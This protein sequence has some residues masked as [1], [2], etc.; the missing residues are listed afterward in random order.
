[1]NNIESKELQ[2]YINS[3]ITAIKNGVAGTGF[4]IVKPIEFNLAVTNTAEGSGGLKIYVA[5]AEGKLK[6]EEIS[7][8][9]F[10]VKPEP[11][12][13]NQFRPNLNSNRN[14]AR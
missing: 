7:H 1:M 3:S 5:K 2:E 14:S 10:E 13:V 6:S 11:K 8:L 9:K 12:I 4:K